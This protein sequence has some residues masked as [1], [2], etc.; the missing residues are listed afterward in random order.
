ML[1]IR[2]HFM[3]NLCKLMSFCSVLGD[4]GCP[5][6]PIE[7]LSLFKLIIPTDKEPRGRQVANDSADAA[8]VVLLLFICEIQ[9]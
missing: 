3:E 9:R 8:R 7:G 1:Y 4:A 6:I 2:P 5:F